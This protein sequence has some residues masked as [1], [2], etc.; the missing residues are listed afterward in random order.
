MAKGIACIVEHPLEPPPPHLPS[1]WRLPEVRAMRGMSRRARVEFLNVDQCQCGA[2][3]RKPTTLLAVNAPGLKDLIR[4]LPGSGK[5][6]H[7]SH[8]EE[9]V[10]TRANGQFSTA[11]AKQYP[12]L[13]SK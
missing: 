12:S 8:P 2:R 10:G 4:Q 9:L 3:S 5:C 7:A 11:A 13:L 1:I 6:N